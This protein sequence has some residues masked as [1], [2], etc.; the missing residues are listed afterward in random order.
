MALREHAFGQFLARGK[1]LFL[2]YSHK[3]SQTASAAWDLLHFQRYI[4]RLIA[5]WRFAACDMWMDNFRRYS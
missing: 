1:I 5:A 4:R 3:R 2:T